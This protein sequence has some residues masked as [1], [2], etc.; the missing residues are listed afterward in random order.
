MTVT[1]EQLLTLAAVDGLVAE[2]QT[3]ISALKASAEQPSLARVGRCY[4]LL[5]ELWLALERLH[6]PTSAQLAAPIGN[7]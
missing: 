2:I 6:Q 1:Q 5:N 4:D 7:G 3:E